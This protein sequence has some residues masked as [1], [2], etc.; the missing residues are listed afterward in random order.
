MDPP[1]QLATHAPTRGV[2]IWKSLQFAVQLQR[3]S[4]SDRFLLVFYLQV[5]I[6]YQQLPDICIEELPVPKL[7]S[8]GFIFIWVINNKY[9]RAFDLMRKW[10]YR[11]RS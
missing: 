6:A 5:A 11:Y 2:W 10:G 8:N 4:D 7:S 1:W 3:C 9:A